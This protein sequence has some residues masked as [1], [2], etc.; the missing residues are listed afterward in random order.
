MEDKKRWSDFSPA[1]RAAILV[2][3]AIEV[4]LTTTALVDLA[5]RPRAQVRGPKLF[6]LLACVVQPVGPISYLMFGRR[7]LDQVGEPVG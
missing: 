2:G 6:W 3:A 1:Q 4:V 7:P 5:K